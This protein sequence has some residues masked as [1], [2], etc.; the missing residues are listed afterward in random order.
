[1]NKNNPWMNL[2][3]ITQLGISMFIPIAGMFFL[4]R[5]L[6][7]RLGTEPLLL[8]VLTILGVLAAFR[9]LFVLGTRAAKNKKKEDDHE[10]NNL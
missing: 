4:G 9:N 10:S 7:S 3:L 8:F 6:D 1:M 5:Y 2:A